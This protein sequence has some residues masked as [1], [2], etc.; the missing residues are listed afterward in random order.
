LIVPDHQFTY[1]LH[2]TSKL[3]RNKIPLL[4]VAAV[5]GALPSLNET[6]KSLVLDE[7]TSNF[8]PPA[9]LEARKNGIEAAIVRIM[10]ARKK[11]DHNALMSE[12]TKQIS[13]RFPADATFIKR[14]IES[15]IEREYIERDQENRRLYT[16]LA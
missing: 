12:V 3:Y 8:I 9:V 16:Y 14:R 1:N 11:L 4:S 10:K 6:A 15:L 2:Y 5:N 13:N 7:N